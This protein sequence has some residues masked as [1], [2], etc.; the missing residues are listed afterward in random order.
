MRSEC[1]GTAP[2]SES[3]RPA[4]GRRDPGCGCTEATR[5]MCPDCWTAPNA[6]EVA[7]TPRYPSGKTWSWSN[8]D[9]GGPDPLTAVPNPDPDPTPDRTSRLQPLIAASA[10]EGVSC[11][12]SGGDGPNR[13]RTESDSIEPNR[14]RF[15]TSIP[16]R[17]S[18]RRVLYGKAGTF[19]GRSMERRHERRLGIDAMLAPTTRCG[20]ST[21]AIGA[22]RAMFGR[23][24]IGLCSFLP[25]VGRALGVLDGTRLRRTRA[26]SKAPPLGGPP[27]EG[28]GTRPS[29]PR[30]GHTAGDGD[31]AS[32]TRQTPSRPHGLQG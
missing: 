30:C 21:S 12:S 11:R 22:L 24:P 16:T 9:A 29:D 26:A 7:P 28:P 31:R 23:R 25:D 18:G 4:C 15:A 8:H 14:G 20:P 3:G 5:R 13:S 1:R 19:A 27:S 32:S 10:I 17:G 2:T 6:T